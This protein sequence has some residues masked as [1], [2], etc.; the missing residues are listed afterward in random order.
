MITL[1]NLDDAWA[2][3]RVREDEMAAFGMGSARAARRAGAETASQ[4]QGQLRCRAAGLRHTWRAAR[5]GGT[6]LRTFEIRLRPA[7]KV[8]G[9]ASGYVGRVSTL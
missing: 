6:D 8:D 9:F 4:F 1:V 5:P 2:V 7:I 3:L